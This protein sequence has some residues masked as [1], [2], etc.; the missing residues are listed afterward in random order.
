MTLTPE[1]RGDL[2]NRMLPV[3]ARLA[4]IAHGDGDVRDVAHALGPL[5]RVELVAVAVALAAMVD[6][7]A[8]LDDLLGHV[9]W[10]EHG[11]PA[12]P[13]ETGRLT[14]RSLMPYHTVTPSGTDALIEHEQRQIIR[15]L[16]LGQGMPAREISPRVG[17]HKRTVERWLGQDKAR[18]RVGASR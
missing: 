9:T 1:E 12:D 11:M 14:L 4:C 5:D 13:T 8:R 3:A 2:A 7:D 6:P 10:D 18:T 16:H 15:S 17:L